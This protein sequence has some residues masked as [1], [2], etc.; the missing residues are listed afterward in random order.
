MTYKDEGKIGN[1]QKNIEISEKYEIEIE[2]DHSMDIPV[3]E[4]CVE[5]IL[6]IEILYMKALLLIQFSYLS[7][8]DERQF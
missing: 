2:V 1:V 8:T 3:Q 5:S 7:P 6:R 4:Y